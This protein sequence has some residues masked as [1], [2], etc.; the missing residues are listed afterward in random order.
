MARKYKGR[1]PKD[2]TE[3]A[4]IHFMVWYIFVDKYEDVDPADIDFREHAEI[5]CYNIGLDGNVQP[6]TG[7]ETLKLGPRIYA[8]I[9]KWFTEQVK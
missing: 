2:G 9:R 1:L 5:W 3:I 7:T 8:G 6:E 4:R